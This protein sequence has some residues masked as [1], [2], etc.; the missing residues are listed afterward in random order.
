MIDSHHS[1]D[2]FVGNAMLLNM[3]MDQ[4]LFDPQADNWQ[5]ECDEMWFLWYPT[6]EPQP[7]FFLS[8]KLYN[9]RL[10]VVNVYECMIPV[11]WPSCHVQDENNQIRLRSWTT[12]QRY[13]GDLVPLPQDDVTEVL[14]SLYLAMHQISM[15][16]MGTLT[17]SRI[18]LRA[19]DD[20]FSY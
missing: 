5:T 17:L 20:V 19:M 7:Y 13:S 15:K 6:F 18:P 1:P 3:G 16:R 11:G 2:G 12:I 8:F 9:R 14:G 10:I 4:N